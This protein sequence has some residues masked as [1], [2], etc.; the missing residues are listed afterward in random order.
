MIG[1]KSIVKNSS[2]GFLGAEVYTT[3]YFLSQGALWT[4]AHVPQ[5]W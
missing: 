1:K 4:G 3:L 5:P 2:L